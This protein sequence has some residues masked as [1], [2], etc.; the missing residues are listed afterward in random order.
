MTITPRASKSSSQ[1]IFKSK[2]SANQNPSPGCLQKSASFHSGLS[3]FSARFLVEWLVLAFSHVPDR[4]L[5]LK[6]SACG[7]EGR[8]QPSCFSIDSA[9]VPP[10]LPPL[11][12]TAAAAHH[13]EKQNTLL[14]HV[15][16]A[17]AGSSVHY[18]PE[19]Y[20]FHRHR[21]EVFMQS[22]IRTTLLPVY[23]HFQCHFLI[24]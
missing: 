12:S 6:D 13:A 2:A 17:F 20:Q 19:S 9:I 24:D 16:V 4:V 18:G 8:P 14:L 7:S 23:L 10:Y 21:R 5:R 3:L 22:P 1:D 11:Y 15:L